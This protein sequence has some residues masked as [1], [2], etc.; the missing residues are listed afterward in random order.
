MELCDQVT[1]T[2]HDGTKKECVI[3]EINNVHG[4]MN[5]VITNVHRVPPLGL[6]PKYIHDLQRKNEILDAIE[7]YIQANEE[8]PIKWIEEYNELVSK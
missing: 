4:V 6:K 8:I 2:L 1:L 3:S 5:Y 7:R